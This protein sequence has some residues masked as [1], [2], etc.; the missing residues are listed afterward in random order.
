M[1]LQAYLSYNRGDY[2]SLSVLVKPWPYHVKG[3]GDKLSQNI[4]IYYRDKFASIYLPPGLGQSFTYLLPFLA[5][6]KIVRHWNLSLQVSQTPLY[7]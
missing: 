2:V 4:S 5:K 3:K 6:H 1:P 7:G